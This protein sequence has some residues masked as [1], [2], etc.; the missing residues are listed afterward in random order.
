MTNFN[1]SILKKDSKDKIT[2][3][4]QEMIFSQSQDQ[5]DSTRK[6]IDVIHHNR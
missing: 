5:I 2:S 6:T 4:D 3:E 1:L